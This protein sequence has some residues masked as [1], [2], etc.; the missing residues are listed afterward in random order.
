[1][2]P[3]PGTTIRQL[4]DITCALE[5]VL[6]EP[7]LTC[8]HSGAMYRYAQKSGAVM[9]TGLLSVR[10]RYLDDGFVAI[11]FVHP[12]MRQRSIPVQTMAGRELPRS[13]KAFRDHLIG[14]IGGAK[15]ADAAAPKATR[16]RGKTH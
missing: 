14:E 15:S 7:D 1:M 10:D 5:G 9:F 2:L 3:E 4:I 13:V 12:Q 16:R 8:N 11:P 6:L